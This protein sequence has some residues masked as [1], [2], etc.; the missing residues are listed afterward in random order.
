[1]K[2]IKKT[3]ELFAAL[4]F[5]PSTLAFEEGNL[6]EILVI[7]EFLSV[8]KEL[9]KLW[10]LKIPIKVRIAIAIKNHPDVVTLEIS[11]AFVIKIEL[12][13]NIK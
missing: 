2:H 5:L 12:P 3:Q 6:F 4:R 10:I 1:M 7:G 8:A 13:A 11:S 9:M